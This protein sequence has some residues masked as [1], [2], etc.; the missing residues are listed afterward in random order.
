MNFKLP[1]IVSRGLG[2]CDDLVDEDK[3]GYIIDVGTH[4]HYLRKLIY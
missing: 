1:V 3:N 4:S 2:T